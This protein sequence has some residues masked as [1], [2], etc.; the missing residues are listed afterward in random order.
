[1]EPKVFLA[2]RVAIESD[3]RVVDEGQFPG[4]QGRLTFAYLVAEQGRAVPRDELAEALWGETPPSTWDKALTGIVS[5]LRSLLADQGVDGANT[6][7]GA[8]GCYRLELP[9]G[10][11]VD[12]LAAATAVDDAEA[13][14][15]AEELDAA[16]DAAALAASVLAQPFLP[17]EDGSWV[18]GKRRELADTRARALGVLTEASLRSGD[19]SEAVKWAEQTIALAPFRESGYRRLMEA[20]VAGG[21]RAEA[22]RVYERCRRLLAD[23]LGTYPSPE[24]ESIYRTLL[25]APEVDGRPAPTPERQ[26]GAAA[27]DRAPSRRGTRRL[28]VRLVAVAL[29]TATAVG[30]AVVVITRG[31]PGSAVAG[32]SSD[33]VGILDAG[34]G[35][36]RGQVAVGASP[37]AV[38]AGDGSIWVANGDANTVSRIDPKKQLVI[39]TIQVGHDPDGVAFGGG[40]V[41]IANSLD[42]TV[43]KLDPRTNTQVDVIP[44]GNGPA[45]V[46]VDSRY[47]WVANSSDGTVTRISLRTDKPL[48]PISVAQSADGVAVGYGSTWVTSKAAGTV[49]R[50]DRRT[51]RLIEPIRSGSGAD[52]VVTGDGAVWV[53]NNLDSTVTRIDPATD[54]VVTV[55]PVGDGPNGIAAADRGL[56]VSN[57]LG[58][59]VSKIDPRRNV[60]AGSV[61]TGNRPEGV[62]V[63]SGSLFVAVRASGIGHRGGTLT[64]LTSSRDL[65]HTDPALDWSQTE[66]QV[67]AL[68]YDGLTGLRRVGGDAGLQPVPDLA[69]SLPAPSPDGRT[70]SFR[71]RPG[72]RYSTGALVR[73]ED[74]RRTIERAILLPGPGFYFDDVVGA[75]RCLAAPKRPCDL[76]QGIVTDRAANTITFHLTAPDPD[77]LYKLTL[78]AASAIPAATPLH[79]HGFAPATGPYEI[80]SFDPKHGIRLVRN[81][82]FHEW[83]PAAQPSGFP[84]EIVERITGTTDA[85]ILAAVRGSADVASVGLNSKPPSPD[86]L[87][88]VRTH[89]ASQLELNPWDITWYL[90]L[91]TRI[92]PFDNLAARQALNLA[93]DRA[94]LRDLTVGSGLGTVTCHIL[95]P[96]LSGYRPYCP[97]TAE[98][99]DHGTWTAPDLARARRLVKTSGT[100]GQTV[101]VWIPRIYHQF[102]AAAG[103]YV[104][105]VL[106]DLG[107]RARYRLAFNPF[108]NEDKLRLQL[109]FNGW[110]PDFGGTT[111]SFITPLLSC[112]S[113]NRNNA[114]NNNSA[115]FCNRGIDREIARARTLQTSDPGAASGL[116]AK[117]DRDLTDQAPWVPY[118]NGVALDVVSTR[119][120]NYQLNPQLGT[121]LDQL[122]VR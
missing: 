116:W 15:A 34:T 19:A 93:V 53:A 21:D 66:V 76:S 78:P 25:E 32:V 101:T 79:L 100:A 31:G 59:T 5:K 2:G 50:I 46:A 77:F 104:V 106:D 105:S 62:A 117:I 80:A 45:G 71:L 113:Y 4:R 55:I 72:I 73:P 24:T 52:A 65:A 3:G 112:R 102:G 33:S 110:F 121:L 29:V 87:Q 85:H 109:G 48:P 42:G 70:Y 108:L 114:L 69:V 6:L 8:F 47:V 10:T 35:H 23:E 94:R 68:A 18:E 122:W 86:V 9:E 89:H 74:F 14:L 39:E 63:D 27:P 1:L 61:T 20:H 95:P 54:K 111:S 91:N 44:V 36:P 40:F 26:T 17:G 22:L 49:T 81:P 57:E 28:A 38:A 90:A 118:A 58:G 119:V 84:D 67:A 120:G 99:S 103:K 41:W 51:G 7:T 12:V 96:N 37:S 64:L 92:P 13:A 16:K 107:Y 30:A 115:E 98:P 56:W 88:F 60:P 43:S 82:R 83:S 97:Y 75:R 11:W